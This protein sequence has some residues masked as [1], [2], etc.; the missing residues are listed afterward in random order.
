MPAI[1]GSQPISFRQVSE[2]LV[3]DKK[4]LAPSRLGSLRLLVQERRD[5][6]R[7]SENADWIEK[8]QIGVD[9]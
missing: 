6:R 5:F 9:W 8:D 3:M 7:K 1:A 2:R 4:G